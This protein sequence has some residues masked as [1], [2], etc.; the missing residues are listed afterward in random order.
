MTETPQISSTQ[1]NCIENKSFFSFKK[2][3][4]A[5]P[6]II[7]FAAIQMFPF[8]FGGQALMP[9]TWRSIHPWARGV[10]VNS[11]N[12]NIYDTVLEYEPWYRYAQTCLKEGR[13]PHWN[14]WQF[15]GA[16]LYA[17]RLIPLFYPPFILAALISSPE[18]LLGWFQFFNLILSGTGMYL[19]LRRWSITSSVAVLSSCLFLT[20]GLHFLPFPPWTLG[21]VGF[22][23][24]IWAIEGFLLKPS[25]RQLSIASFIT[26]NILLAGYPVLV[27]HL[28]YFTIMYAM[29]RWIML[30]RGNPRKFAWVIFII[31]L[32]LNFLLGSGLASIANIPAY[33]YSKQTVRNIEGFVDR[34]FEREKLRLL[35][36]IEEAGLDPVAARFGERTDMFLPING[37][38]TQRAWLYAG[39]LIYLLA[40]LGILGGHPVAHIIAV[41][42]SLFGALVLVPEIYL[43]IINFLPG[44]TVSILLPFEVVNFAACILAAFGLEVLAGSRWQPDKAGKLIFILLSLTSAVLT[45]HWLIKAPV[46]NLPILR[47]VPDRN[48]LAHSAF[49]LSYLIIFILLSL[50]ICSLLLINARNILFKWMLFVVILCFS[51]ATHWYLQPVYS[52]IDYM[53]PTPFTE[54]IAT[55]P[56]PDRGYESGNRI[57]RWAD[58]PLPFNPHKR[59]KSPFTPNL[60]LRYGIQDVGGYDSLVPRRFI[61]YCSLF[62][63]A[64]MEY[65]ALIAF[66]ASSIARHPRFRAMGV[67]WIIS[68]GI[69][70]KES[71][72]ECELVWDDRIQ[73]SQSGSDDSDDFIQVWKIR[74]PAPRAF[75][76]RKVAFNSDPSDDPIVQAANLAAQ[77]INA[78]V[79]ED[80]SRPNRSFAF[81]EDISSNQSL[82]LPDSEV[83]IEKD[84]PERV[85]LTVKSNLDCYLILRDGWYPEWEAFI[86]DQ[87]TTIYP[88]DAAFRAVRIPP[89]EHKVIFSYNPRSYRLGM[90]TTII[91]LIILFALFTIP[92]KRQRE[93]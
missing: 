61:W 85:E 23:W 87:P 83:I 89:G 3:W 65:R 52:P 38:G 13:I 41:L 55:I 17:N 19:L 69:L 90:W 63:D 20:T 48:L 5:F 53:P 80:A 11:N 9:D 14:P 28:I 29:V 40:V 39:V 51:L 15:C 31:A 76:T 47:F 78:V 92:E 70:P 72:S 26:G 24:L 50:W 93:A 21:I 57:A 7:A 84:E 33:E 86:D 62:E 66:K 25:F 91:T 42:G 12:A 4:I 45:Y 44:W 54:W 16:P 10:D 34:A 2:E 82:I 37:R 59:E 81:P 1:Q 18:R 68:Q 35:T 75:L 49:H 71:Q 74:N 43:G 46:V 73:G 77:K 64:I 88:A 30:N 8:T 58:L 22:P 56:N 67:K 36:P 32:L 6:I 27:V 60:H 79:V